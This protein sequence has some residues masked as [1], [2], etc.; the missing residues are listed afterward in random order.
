MFLIC[1]MLKSMFSDLVRAMELALPCHRV[2]WHSTTRLDIDSV[3]SGPVIQYGGTNRHDTNLLPCLDV[4]CLVVL[5][6]EPPLAIYMHVASRSSSVALMQALLFALAEGL[7]RIPS[8]IPVHVAVAPSTPA[9]V[10]RVDD[11]DGA[12]RRVLFLDGDLRGCEVSSTVA[13]SCSRPSSG[14]SAW[15]RCGP[16]WRRLRPSLHSDRGLRPRLH[17]HLEKIGILPLSN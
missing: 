13:E 8:P 10:A 5:C 17:L 11:A 15:T 1:L 7:V 2:W 9:A 12:R 16:R 3:V 14:D 4:S 6:R